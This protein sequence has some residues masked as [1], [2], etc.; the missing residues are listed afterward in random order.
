[1]VRKSPW[2]ISLHQAL[3]L[4]YRQARAI[5]TV[6]APFTRVFCLGGGRPTRAIWVTSTISHWWLFNLHVLADT[7]RMPFLHR[8]TPCA[9]TTSRTCVIFH[10]WGTARRQRQH[11]CKRRHLSPLYPIDETCVQRLLTSMPP[12]SWWRESIGWFHLCAW[13]LHWWFSLSLLCIV[14]LINMLCLFVMTFN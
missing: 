14:L 8:P 1:M 13:A 6:Y 11:V 3:F 5:R 9:S 12:V 7:R 10:H 4:M 2:P